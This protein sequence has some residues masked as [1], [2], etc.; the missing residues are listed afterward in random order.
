MRDQ[1]KSALL[2]AGLAAAAAVVLAPTAD[3]RPNCNDANST[4]LCQTDGHVAIKTAP[5]TVAT[6]ADGRGQIPWQTGGRRTYG[7]GRR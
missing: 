1:G 5:G 7:G 3:A 4:T 6:P 2:M